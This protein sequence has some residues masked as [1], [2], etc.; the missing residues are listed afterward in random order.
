[1]TKI[2]GQGISI[3]SQGILNPEYDRFFQCEKINK[4]INNKP[5]LFVYCMII[6]AF[7]YVAFMD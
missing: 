6:V 5:T 1:M 4:R 7:G 2:E 3:A